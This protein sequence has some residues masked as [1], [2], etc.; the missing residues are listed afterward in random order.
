MARIAVDR[1]K[2]AD[3]CR[4]HHIRKLSFFGSVLR[5]DFGPESDVDVLVEFVP[6][7]EPSLLGMARME[8]ELEDTP[9]D[10]ARGRASHSGGSQ[11]VLRGR[12]CRFGG[13]A[14]CRLT[15][16]HASEH[17]LEAAQTAAAFIAGRK[18]D[19]LDSD[20]ML[21]F[22]LGACAGNHR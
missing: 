9:G 11:P 4:R 18:R 12:C 8:F 19:D 3:F 6:G 16:R 1:D 14:L 10:Q 5:D 15:I 21:L 22:A 13:T 2:I 20:R 17:M 7:K